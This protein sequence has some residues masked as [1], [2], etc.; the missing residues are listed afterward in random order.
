MAIPKYDEMYNEFLEILKDGKEKQIKEIKEKLAVIF[1]LSE[2]ENKAKLN[3]GKLLF[4]NRVGWTSTYL[5]KAGLINSDSR[6]VFYITKEGKKFIKENIK[7]DNNV[8][9]EIPMFNN[10]I[11]STFESINQ[12]NVEEHTPQEQIELSIEQLN[13]EL[14]DDLLREILNQ[15][16]TFFEDLT[17]KLMIAMKYGKPQNA[18]RTP[19]SND[20]GIDGIVFGDALELN[21]IYIQAKRYDKQNHVSRPELQ[22]FAGAMLDKNATKGVFITTSSF[23]KSAQEFAK[24]QNIALIDGDRLTDLMIEYKI[25]CYTETSYEIKKI[26]L[27]FFENE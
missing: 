23:T 13:N 1:K 17:I 18:I 19:L 10:F 27:D 16:P 25:G 22:K 11:N 8:L 20:G 2:E 24:K 12:E 4:N 3:S 5:K 9:K 15:S 6:G 14:K 26:D 7:I 21:P